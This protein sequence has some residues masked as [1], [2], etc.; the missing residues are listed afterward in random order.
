MD[1][2]SA[3]RLFRKTTELGSFA[4]AARISGITAAAVGKS[5]GE[6]EAHLK[7]R[8]FNRTTRRMSLTEAGKLYYE[9]IT[10]LIEQ[11]EEADR[12]LT[13]HH[14]KPSGLLRVTAPLTMTIVSLSQSIP[15][16]LER[17]PDITL[18][19]NL[20][21]RQIDIIKDGYDI[22]IKGSDNLKNSSLIGR[23]FTT[24]NHVICASPAYF[25]CYGTPR[26]P[27]D[28]RHHNCIRYNLSGHANEWEFRK[29][30]RTERIAIRGRYI[31]SSSF[32]VRDALCAG[33]GLS[34]IPVSYV[35]DDIA[36]GRLITALDDWQQVE[37]G[38]YV[39]YPSRRHLAPKV[40][41]F[42]DFLNEKLK[43]TKIAC[44]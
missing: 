14:N 42:L 5:I 2:L 43:E 9:Q 27:A 15:E 22:A 44:N 12:S 38:I 24:L 1:Q 6:L 35:R 21:D 31:V 7:V 33:F 36:A 37:T 17:Y 41:V 25:E 40:R 29:G 30:E 16:F 32:A 3:L 23:K 10:P 28:L 8:L 13:P 4:E 20:D 19:L 11:L 34:L 26:E 39:F 18:E